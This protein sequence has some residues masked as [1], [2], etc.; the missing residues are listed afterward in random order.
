MKKIIIVVSILLGIF[1]TYQ[2]VF[3]KKKSTIV[4]QEMR[5]AIPADPNSFDPRAVIDMQSQCI[6]MPLFEGLMRLSNEGALENGIADSYSINEEKTVYTFQLKKTNW[7]NGDRVTAHNFEKA[8]KRI[9]SPNFPTKA[10]FFFNV[11][12]NAQ[13]AKRGDCPIDDVGVIAV[14]DYTLQVTLEHPATYFLELLTAPCFAPAHDKNE[15]FFSSHTSST[16]LISNGPFCFYSWSPNHSLIFKKNDTYWDRTNVTLDT[17]TFS[18]IA[19]AS[20]ALHLFEQGKIDYLDAISI[21]VESIPSLK[22]KKILQTI[23]SLKMEWLFVNVNAFPVNNLNFRKALSLSI[24]RPYISQYFY[25]NGETPASNILPKQLQLLDTVQEEFSPEPAKALLTKSMEEMGLNLDTF[26]QIVLKGK[27]LTQDMQLMQVL[28]EQWRK[29]LGLDIKIEVLDFKLLLEDVTTQNFQIALL[30]WASFFNDPIYNLNSLNSEISFTGWENKDY[31]SLIE[32]SNN[33]IDL[34]QRRE[35]LKQATLLTREEMPI[36]PLFDSP[37]YFVLNSRIG[38][39]TFN[40][41]GKPIF[42]YVKTT[43]K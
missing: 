18:I 9:I 27:P 32:L 25:Y 37:S 19:D 22:K 3:A 1:V 13:K 35:L 15:S 5:I 39:L 4:Q 21:P 34:M 33:T 28:Q 16:S 10:I 23:D 24:N 2:S 43:K 40:A 12:K 30:S 7:S 29:Y 42:T 38:N 14:D 8:W 6:L 36:I 41:F 26:P 11:I 31:A 17:L 20:T